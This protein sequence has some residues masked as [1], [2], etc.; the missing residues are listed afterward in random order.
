MG[1]KISKRYS[2]SDSFFGQA[3]SECEFLVT[4]HTEV[5]SCNFEISNFKLKKKNIG[6]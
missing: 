4:I 6:I 2:Y 1:V 3:F 5:A